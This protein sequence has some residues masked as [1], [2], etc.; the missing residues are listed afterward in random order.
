MSITALVTG[1]RHRVHAATAPFVRT[2][3]GGLLVQG[4]Y[5]PASAYQ[6]AVFPEMAHPVD[7]ERCWT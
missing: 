1:V 3:C 4:S 7:C 5:D 2:R 6:R